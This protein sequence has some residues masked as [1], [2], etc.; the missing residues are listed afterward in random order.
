MSRI[1]WNLHPKSKHHGTKP[2]HPSPLRA[3]P[4]T[5]KTQSEASQYSGSHNY[6]TKHLPS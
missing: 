5:S 1:S 6:K 2:M 3:F 4:K